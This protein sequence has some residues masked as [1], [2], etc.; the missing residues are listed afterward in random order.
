[1]SNPHIHTALDQLRDDQCIA[2]N[3]AEQEAHYEALAQTA[4]A[5][6]NTLMG[7]DD[8]DSWK[9]ENRTGW[10]TMTWKEVYQQIEA[11][12]SEVRELAAYMADHPTDCPCFLPEQLCAHDRRVRIAIDEELPY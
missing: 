10:Q 1:M 12:I 4:S 9:N 8:F 11:K 5:E 6:L 2:R 3:R 7:D